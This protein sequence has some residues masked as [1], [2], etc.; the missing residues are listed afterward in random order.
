VVHGVGTVEDVLGDRVGG[1]C[2]PRRCADEF[3]GGGRRQYPD[4]V[5]CF[6]EQA[7]ERHRL[8]RGDA[9]GHAQ[10]DPQGGQSVLPGWVTFRT[11]ALVSR[12]AIDN[13]FSWFSTST[14][15]PTCSRRPSLSWA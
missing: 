3:Q 2:L 6:T 5:A 1:E 8:V 12:M 4:L 11:P 14:S 15:G 7:Q 9:S 10:D 13:G